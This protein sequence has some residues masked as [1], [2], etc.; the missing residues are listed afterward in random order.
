M[1]RTARR[2][3]SISWGIAGARA[4]LAQLVKDAENALVPFGA[5]ATILKDAARFVAERR[6]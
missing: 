2:R 1:P 3:W 6:T 5:D 4:R